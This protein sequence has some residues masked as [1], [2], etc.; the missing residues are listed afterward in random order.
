MSAAAVSVPPYKAIHAIIV[1]ACRSITMA[2]PRGADGRID[3][4][5]S[6]GPYL[7]KLKMIL[8]K[9]QLP[10]EIPAARCWYDIRISGI[11]I[12]LKLTTCESA[13]NAGSSWKKALLYTKTGVEPPT[14]SL[15]FNK[16]WTE[17]KKATTKSVRDPATEYHYLVVNKT[18]GEFFFKSILD[19]HPATPKPNAQNELQYAW[20]NEF[21]NVAYSMPEGE[22]EKAQTRLVAVVQ[23]SCQML[24]STM[25]DF[26]AADLTA[27]VAVIDATATGGAATGGVPKEEAT[28][29]D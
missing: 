4:A 13:D 8:E 17:W 7:D 28:T 23:K 6:E 11:P 3:S 10:V 26:L 12:N 25:A 15:N 2:F 20:K 18:T 1:A 24:L 16:F 22:Q 27:S 21:A 19:L 5:N 9:A 14:A 29:T